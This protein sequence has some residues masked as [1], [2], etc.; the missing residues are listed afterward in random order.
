MYRLMFHQFIRTRICQ[1]G[2]TFI[3]IL[4]FISIITGNQFLKLHEQNVITATQAQ[5][6]H[7]HRNL[8]YHGDDLPLLLYYLKFSLANE[9]SPLAALSIGQKDLNP[10]VQSVGIL[11]L[12]AQKY[13]TDIVNPV[14]LLFGN[15][16]FSF[17][18]IYVFPLIVI[19]FSYN[20]LS[21]EKESGTWNMVRVMHQSSARF[22]LTKLS[23][24]ISLLWSVLTLVFIVAA[25]IL[26]IS[27]DTTFFLLYAGSIFY[28]LF[29]FA[30]SFWVSVLRKRSSVNAL[31]LLS[32]WLL[33]VVIVPS[34]VNS[35][36]TTSYPIPEALTTMIKQR[37]GYHQ[38]WDENKQES[39]VKFYESYPQFES[40]G[41]PPEQGFDWFWYYAIQ[42]LGDKES[43]DEREQ[44]NE[45]IM[46]REVVS[47]RW[48]SIIP[49]M[50]LQLFFND[51]AGT[52]LINHLAFLRHIDAFHEDTRLFFYPEIYKNTSAKVINWDRFRPQ[53]FKHEKAF[54]N[55]WH[56]LIP[57]VI[58][59]MIFAILSTIS[60]TKLDRV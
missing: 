29:W 45:K 22:L 48:A 58:G 50:H 17:L 44:M 12:T 6:V 46:Q 7:V 1:L 39:M 11:T 35:A 52:S 40:F 59:L 34:M 32:L 57:L 30:A 25:I 19:A 56:G 27:I 42:F 14:K 20:L 60:V 38:K 9:V 23:V 31:S 2:I 53:V 51:L 55:R 5:E 13:D 54:D 47:R 16:D 15:L 10:N 36:I 8:E 28:L 4:A 41:F 49:P 18:L 33:L 21:E 43:F 26:D 37:D 24:R 3:L